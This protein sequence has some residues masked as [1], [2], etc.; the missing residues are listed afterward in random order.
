[1]PYQQSQAI[2]HRLSAVLQLIR[3]GRYST[4]DLADELEVSIPTI[5]RCVTALRERGHTIRAEKQSAG[6]RY[7]LLN[8]PQSSNS[9]NRAV[10]APRRKAR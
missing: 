5:S 9:H 8:G 7:V 10:P 4:P 1:M 6:W 3:T 2:E